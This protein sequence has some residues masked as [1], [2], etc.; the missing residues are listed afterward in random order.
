MATAPRNAGRA[1]PAT[2]HLPI[3]GVPVVEGQFTPLA[4]AR[5]ATF[6]MDNF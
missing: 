4:P 2:L 5:F 1:P 3:T 6:T